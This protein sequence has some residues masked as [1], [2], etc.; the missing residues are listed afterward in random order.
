MKRLL[1]IAGIGLGVLALAV[2][3]APLFINVDD[4]RPELESR[5]SV[6]LNRRVNVGKLQAS[7]FSGGAKAEDISIADDPAFSKDPFLQASS[8][9]VGLR[10]VPLIFSRQLNV[11]SI[12]V[13]NPD[14]VLL[15]NA[16]GKW[17]YSSLGAA[18]SEPPSANNAASSSS[19]EFSVGKFEI[20]GGKVR[21]GQSSGHAASR[22]RVYQNVHLVATNI[23]LNSAMPFTLTADTPGG[24]ALKLDGQAGPLNHQDSAMTPLAA[25][26]SLK[27]VDLGATGFLDAGSGLGGTLDFDGKVDSDGHKMHARGKA[28]ASGLKV[29]KGGGRSKVPLSLDYTSEFSLDSETGNINASLHEGNSTASASG[30]IDAHGQDAI[31]HLKI[32]GKD[33]AVN[34]LE[35]LL[36]AFGVVLPAGSSLEGGVANLDMVAEGPLDRLV[37]SGPLNIS[38]TH[39]KGYNLSS[40]LGALAAFSGIKP[41]EDTLIQTVSSGLRVAPEGIRA[42]SIVLN[43]PSM[44]SLTG[45]GVVNSNNSLDFQMVLKLSGTPGNVLGNLVGFRGASQN[46]GIPFLIQGTT[47][48]PQ[49]RPNLSGASAS[50]KNALLG[51]GQNPGGQQQ[52][53][54]GLLDGLLNKKKKQQ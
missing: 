13:E 4:F 35:K 7:I 16:A 2:V 26:A 28:Q 21:V 1:I 6:A 5:L 39:L 18:P 51:N 32:T 37:I 25:E 47:S 43:V 12:T 9:K 27:H 10:M 8:L 11:T 45:G 19:R 36:P 30:T 44:G 31:A 29:V 40:K 14:I 42:D 46:Q 22:E 3:L 24:G 49:F 38:N 15:K 41:S 48:N 33:M 20:V 52:G 17:N 23:S 54:G 53:L 34:D 50:L